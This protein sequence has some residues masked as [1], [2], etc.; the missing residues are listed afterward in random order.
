ML[1]N[2][3]AVFA[4]H[5]KKSFDRKNGSVKTGPIFFVRLPR[6]PYPLLS[7]SDLIRGSKLKDFL[8]QVFP[9]R[10]KFIYKL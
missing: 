7:P 5:S 10:I 3:M 6:L 8:I 4:L 9:L 2:G 1:T